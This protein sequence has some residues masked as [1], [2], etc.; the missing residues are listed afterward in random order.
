MVPRA[1]KPVP[2]PSTTI[3]PTTAPNP[4]L[5]ADRGILVLRNPI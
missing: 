3:P 1:N 4:A 2:A 5:E